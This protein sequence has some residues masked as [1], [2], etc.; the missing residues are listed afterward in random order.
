MSFHGELRKRLRRVPLGEPPA[1][2]RKASVHTVGGLTGVGFAEGSDLLL[3]V[4][5]QGRG[6][7]DCPCGTRIA[8]DE[9]PPHRGWY[10]PIRLI[11]TGI[12][13]LCDQPIRIAGLH[14]GGLPTCT[15]DGWRTT[16][17]APDWPRE[18]IVLDPRN[19]TVLVEGLSHGSIR[20]AEDIDIRAHG[21]SETGLS[22]I[23]ATADRVEVWN[24][25]RPVQA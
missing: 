24:R 3:V 16:K 9:E 14:G 6:L 13:P 25:A 1:P 5:H 21:F 2:W 4:S 18:S 15:D 23:V 10:D 17:I 7:F 19:S 8:R 20:I 12:G 22:L 11:A